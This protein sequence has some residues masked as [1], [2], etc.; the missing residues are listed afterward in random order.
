MQRPDRVAGDHKWALNIQNLYGVENRL[1]HVQ[2]NLRVMRRDLSDKL[3]EIAAVEQETRRVPQVITANSE[4]LTVSGLQL[5]S[6]FNDGELRVQMLG[7]RYTPTHPDMIEAVKHLEE[8]RA[9]MDLQLAIDVEAARARA[10]RQ[11]QNKL[12]LLRSD[13]DAMY[14]SIAGLEVEEA[15]L[16]RKAAEL[17]SNAYTS[18]EED[19]DFLRASREYTALSDYYRALYR[20]ER[21]AEI[22]S[23]VDRQGQGEMVELLDPP[24]VPTA[25]EF[26]AARSKLAI[27]AGAGLGLGILLGVLRM[28]VRPTLRTARHLNYWQGA[29]LLADLPAGRLGDADAGPGAGRKGWI[30]KLTRIT[31]FMLAMIL[32]AVMTTGCSTSPERAKASWL[33]A[34][35]GAARDGDV[36]RAITCYR[37]VIRLDLRNGE[38][39]KALAGALLSI[40]EVEEALGH[41]IR[42]AELAPGDKKVQ[43]DLINL[44]Y[45]IYHSDPGK[46]RGFLMELEE[47][48]QR[49]MDRWPGEATGYRAMAAVLCERGRTGEACDLVVRGLEKTRQDPN[50]IVELA[51]LKYRMNERDEAESLLRQLTD[52][53]SKFGQAYDL[54]YLQFRDRNLTEKSSEVLQKKWRVIG[55]A[56]SGIQ[57]AAHLESVGDR[58]GMIEQVEEVNRK[59]GGQAETVEVIGAFWASRGEQ[60]MARRVYEGGVGR[61]PSQRSTFIGK[62]AELEVAAGKR[63][64]AM[65]RIRAALA[66]SPHDMTLLSY[67]AALEVDAPGQTESKASRLEL[68]MLMK[69]MPKSA[70]VRFHLGRSYMKLGD[71]YRAGKELERCV[72]LDP[73]YA[74]GWLALA[75]NEY[76]AG[77]MVLSKSTLEHLLQRA[78]RYAGA[79]MLKARILNDLGNRR[80]TKRTLEQAAEAGAPIGEVAGERARL[81]MREGD[82][83]GAIGLLE[84]AIRKV[85]FQTG[86]VVALA[87]AEEALANGD[88]ALAILRKAAASMPDS[89]EIEAAQAGTLARLG[90]HEESAGIYR[91]L[92]ASAPTAL[93]YAA[94]LADALAMSGKLK[95]ALA[96]YERAQTLP[97]APADDMGQIGGST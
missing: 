5:R 85:G 62:L 38:A 19:T 45:R 92:S 75:E 72:R 26:P 53:G 16:T 82:F 64:E 74:P 63:G 4:A 77:N 1:G 84:E 47:Q 13:R 95:E 52:K 17:R 83:R 51:S 35:A 43:S 30:P 96:E 7:K 8:L 60:D 71:L 91:R 66:I 69:R 24:T 67:K 78:P 34:A 36:Y 90:R 25:P 37:N 41:L 49:M 40:G 54:M 33:K 68:E 6:M 55:D 88:K 20:K 2:S 12:D 56:D 31:G 58:A 48:A 87:R 46:S 79:L 57:L 80:E 14:T 44:L 15:S 9:Q 50:L 81:R 61:F 22:A 39:H 23:E 59:L 28:Q 32:A 93:Q 21:D 89:P 65:A 3:T 97:G 10:R 76:R 29:V 27:G 70:F 18:G 11:L 94:G 86:L 42:A 73:N